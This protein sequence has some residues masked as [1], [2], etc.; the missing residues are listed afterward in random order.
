MTP[1]IIGIDLGTTYSLV[2]VL[3]AGQPRVLGNALG[4]V[5]TASAVSVRE[6]GEILVGAPARARAV[7]APTSTAVAFKRDMGTDRRL[8]LGPLELTPVQLSALVLKALKADAEAALGQEVEEAIL[9][10]PAY[11]G[12]LQRQATRD[13]GSLAGLRVERIIN[14]PTAAALA[15]GLQN[16]H[17]EQRVAVLDLGG[18]TFDV[19]VLEIVEGVIEV[20]ATAGDARLGG[21][22]FD[23][24]LVA[25]V[26]ERLGG[27]ADWSG[28]PE[29]MARLRDACQRARHALSVETATRLELPP[30]HSGL[31]VS[32]ELALTLERAQCEAAWRP[33]L[34]RLRQPVE[35]A[36]R[37]AG[38]VPGK[39]D[40]VLLVGGATRM[41]CVIELATRLFGKPPLRTLPPDEA[42]AL[43]AAVQAGLKANDRALDDVVATDVAPFSLGV[44]ASAR[45]GGQLVTDLFSPLIE[46]GTPIPCSRVKC[47]SPVADGQTRVQV[48]VYQGEHAE[49]QRNQLLGRYEVKDLPPLPAEENGLDFRFTYDLNGILEVEI[50][51]HATGAR[52]SFVLER[53]GGSLT[54][55]QLAAAQEAMR[56]W[57]VHPRELLPNTTALE[58]ADAAYVTLLGAERE[59][60]AGAIAAFKAALE[61]QEA[62]EI[63]TARQQLTELTRSFRGR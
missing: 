1:P 44:A 21:E 11:F 59:L 33:L 9:T 27:G 17:Q 16:R 18:G 22:D 3:E 32:A 52:E 13:A 26:Q 37:D 50:T 23:D 28:E 25:L 36:L 20:Q 40:Q 15:Y 61:S 39:L 56:R 35:R 34:E 55:Q 38:L 48:D 49:C 42:I 12:D 24:A 60:L 51:R 14:E 31:G 47:F 53:R 63:A 43:G 4:E 41:P 30:R 46:R 2:A 62:R 7:T 6:D 45:V 57:K 29:L 19:T 58:R 8:K 5:L 10:V 54:S